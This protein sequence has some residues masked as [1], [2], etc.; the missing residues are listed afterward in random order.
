MNIFD[1]LLGYEKLMLLCGFMLFVFALVVIMVM[2]VQRRD[3]KAATVLIIFAIV[4]MGFPG[5]QAIKFSKD[6]V[7]VDRIRASTPGDAAQKQQ[8]QRT[9]SEV[10]QRAE[11]NPQLLA[12]VSDGYRAIGDVN[13]AYQLAQS[14][15][16]T[17]PSPAVQKTLVPVLTAKLNQVQAATPVPPAVTPSSSGADA[18][19]ATE[20]PAP[21]PPYHHVSTTPADT[22]ASGAAA[23]T[24]SAAST[25]AADS[26]RQQQIATIAGQ[27]QGTGGPLPAASHAA[28]A[29]AYVVLGEPQKAQ[30]NVDAAFKLNP[31]IKINAAVLH[32]ARVGS[33]PAEH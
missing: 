11:G 20:S 2:I 30:A 7:E 25:T 28:L 18:P 9:L 13:T 6:M 32:A 21:P 5:I 27:L 3:F 22:T 33:R 1:G 31:N 8:D 26:A 4:L 24:P 10:Q 17:K 16:Q 23:A 14:I 12:Q 19:P 29:K 15:L